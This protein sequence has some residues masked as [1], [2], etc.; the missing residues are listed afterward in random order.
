MIFNLKWGNCLNL[1]GA[2]VDMSGLVHSQVHGTAPV[3][4]RRTYTYSCMFRINYNV[5][6]GKMWIFPT[7]EGR[8]LGLV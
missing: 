1:H 5:K 3:M 2:H 4:P 6:D 7:L 8:T